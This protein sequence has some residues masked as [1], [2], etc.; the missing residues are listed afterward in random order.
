M[1]AGSYTEAVLQLSSWKRGGTSFSAKL[2]T[3]YAG[4]DMGNRAR[5]KAAF[6]HEIAAY[7][8]WQNAPDEGAFFLE[9]LNG[10][11]AV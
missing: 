3:L 9:A 6:P 1:A 10:K 7:E 4:A 5:L 8:A 11:P 2:F